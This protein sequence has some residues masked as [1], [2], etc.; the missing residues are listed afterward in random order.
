MD[1]RKSY[2]AEFKAKVVLEL[3]RKEK[4]ASQIASE[5]EVYPNLLSRWKAE[6]IERM[7]ELFD[8]R[9]SKTEKLKSEFVAN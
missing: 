7:P 4:S 6:A 3:L 2:T 1:K 9:T 5:Y 8:K